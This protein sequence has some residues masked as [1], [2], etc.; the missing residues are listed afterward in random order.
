VLAEL[1]LVNS[2]SLLAREARQA[3]HRLERRP[4]D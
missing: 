2:P 4:A 3:L 1:G